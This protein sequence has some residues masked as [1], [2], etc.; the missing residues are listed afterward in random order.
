M[1]MPNVN[2]FIEKRLKVEEKIATAAKPKT[3]IAR[4]LELAA[5]KKP[6]IVT[7]VIL[8]ALAAIV[9]FIFYLVFVPS[10]A[11]V[12]M[13]IMYV[14]SG[15]MQIVGGMERMDEILHTP[16]LPQP[17]NPQTIA[18]HDVVFDLVSFAYPDQEADALS[19]VSFQ[20]GENQI[21]AI[22]GPSGGGKSTI[23]HLI[24]RFFDVR[25]GSIR[26]GGVDVRNMKTDYL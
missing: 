1:P 13:K 16:P 3:G 17:E 6:L 18:R 12:M 2:I 15:G 20:A 26:I 8:S 5:T 7:A 23:A 22:V 10:I 21:T 14:T 25:E 19:G 9:T 4:L 11:T 24:P